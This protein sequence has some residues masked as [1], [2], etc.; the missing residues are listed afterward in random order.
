MHLLNFTKNELNKTVKHL[1]DKSIIKMI[2]RH[3]Y[4]EVFD[5]DLAT[6]RKI[7]RYCQ[8]SHFTISSTGNAMLVRFR[9]DHSESQGGFHIRYF[10]GTVNK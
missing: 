8:P 4:V 3:D 5:G 1:Q 6:D 7:G 10:T 9:S 2:F